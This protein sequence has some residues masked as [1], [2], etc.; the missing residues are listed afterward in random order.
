VRPDVR[1]AWLRLAAACRRGGWTRRNGLGLCATL[2][3]FRYEGRPRFTQAQYAAINQSLTRHAKRFGLVGYW[4]P[5]DREGY[6]R[7]VVFCR[8]KAASR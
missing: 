7:R 6:A 1:A 2:N 4:W 3:H 5:R 8:R